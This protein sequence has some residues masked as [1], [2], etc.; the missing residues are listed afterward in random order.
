MKAFLNW[1][2][3]GIQYVKVL[4]RRGSTEFTRK[5]GKILFY[6]SNAENRFLEGVQKMK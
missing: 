1:K 4:K 6:R 5:I 3:G 2:S